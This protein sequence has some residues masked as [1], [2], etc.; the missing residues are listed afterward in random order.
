MQECLFKEDSVIPDFVEEWLD[1]VSSKSLR[2]CWIGWLV[3][4]QLH[5]DMYAFIVNFLTVK[6]HCA[7]LPGMILLY[8]IP[9]ILYSM[10]IS[11]WSIQ[12]LKS[13]AL[14]AITTNADALAAG[15]WRFT[16]VYQ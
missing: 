14:V 8:L 11:G 7:V 6:R 16:A 15:C 3:V 13:I 2:W 10:G 12:Y 5:F 9:T 4:I 1:Y